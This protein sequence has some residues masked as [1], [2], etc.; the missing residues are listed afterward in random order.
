MRSGGATSLAE[1]GVNPSH[2]QAIGRW[3]SEAFQVYIRKN[4]VVLHALLFG[5]PVHQPPSGSTPS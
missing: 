4:P 3:T 2:I 1:S 5:R